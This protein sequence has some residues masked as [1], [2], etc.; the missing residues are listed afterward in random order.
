M[1]QVV[2]TNKK[3]QTMVI[4]V[5]TKKPEEICIIAKDKNKPNT[6][7]VK[8]KGIVNGVRDFELKFPKSPS[9]TIVAAYNKKSGLI[10]GT[11]PTFKI[12]DF[13][14]KELAT[15][16]IWMSPETISF[17]KFAQEFSE[18]ASV[19]SAGD[20]IP[21]I[22]RSDD[23][24]FNFDYYL[25]IRDR[26]TGD[27]V[28]TPARIGHLTGIIEISKKD[29]LKYSVPMRMIILLHEYSHKYLNPKINREISYETGADI[30]ALLLYFS[31]GYSEM[32]AHQAFLYVFRGADNDMNHKR[33]LI[34][35]DFIN[36]YS[37]GQI[38]NCY[39]KT[40]SLATK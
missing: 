40:E 19:L 16:P 31:L 26:Q 13:K 20:K 4:R 33:Y 8:R 18:N 34:I 12:S 37:K 7:Y 11:D 35:K 28:N 1:I 17:I 14:T 9:E 27:Y 32:E 36:K 6:F 39:A 10:Q 25:R 15:C 29:F 2:Q 3:P 21:H 30:N 5:E 38:N 24:K 23:G 22:Y